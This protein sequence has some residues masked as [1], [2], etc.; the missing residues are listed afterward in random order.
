MA[1]EKDTGIMATRYEWIEALLAKAKPDR[2]KVELRKQLEA[3]ADEIEPQGFQVPYA[4]L[5]RSKKPRDRTKE[6]IKAAQNRASTIVALRNQRLDGG[7]KELILLAHAL[8]VCGL[9]YNNTNERQI[10]KRAR[11]ADGS[12]IT[13]TFT[14]TD[15]ECSMPYG[16]D[17]TLLHWLIDKAIRTNSAYISWDSA[18]EFLKDAG[19]KSAGKNYQDLRDRYNRLSALAITIARGQDGHK[20][21]LVLPIIEESNLPSTV[22][23]KTE[24]RGGR[25]LL[26]D[27]YG[28]KLNQR[29]F[30]DVKEFHVPV[31]WEIIRKT[32]KQ[33]QL[34]DLMIWLYWRSF[35]AKK[36]SSIPI[37]ALRDQF[38]TSDS[39]PWRLKQRVDEAIKTLKFIDPDFPC[40][41]QGD[42][43]LVK[44]YYGFLP[45]GVKLK[46]IR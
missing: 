5:N 45:E 18:V 16:S 29:F 19:L 11:M 33:S 31:P 7:W 41:V 12:D 14:A 25:R 13:V 8:V 10:V 39:N 36:A 44:P 15:S 4:Y 32:R 26:G 34:Q 21:R 42:L 28:F 9:P 46:T 6:R 17:R 24:R 37:D 3:V 35:A 1:T 2:D 23:L 20:R 43:I 30:E 22:D 38:H 40:G 27:P